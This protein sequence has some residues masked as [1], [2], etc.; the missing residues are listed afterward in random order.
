MT[1]SHIKKCSL[2][3]EIKGIT[4]GARLNKI[5]TESLDVHKSKYL[6]T[7]TRL[8][9]PDENMTESAYNSMLATIFQ[10]KKPTCNIFRKSYV[11]HYYPKLST[12]LQREIATRMRHNKNTAHVNYM[13]LNL[14]SE[15]KPK[16]IIKD[17]DIELDDE[18]LPPKPVKEPTSKTYFNAKEHAKT[19]RINNIEK[20][21]EQGKKHD[22]ENKDKILKNKI[23]LMLNIS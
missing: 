11:N 14:P 8:L 18:D 6:F 9:N 7:P 12:T 10:P 5:I 2:S 16:K 4:D 19:Y 20:I 13:K 3:D 1:R 15:C 21:T 22:E 17:V 23:L